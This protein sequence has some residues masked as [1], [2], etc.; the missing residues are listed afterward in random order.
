M[1]RII[2]KTF[3]PHKKNNPRPLFWHPVS[4]SFLSLA[5][6][7]ICSFLTFGQKENLT[8][9]SLLGDVRSGAI[10]SFTNKER[11][12]I[13]VQV[14]TESKTL[15]NAAI[16][17]A[18]DMARNGYF[19]HYS[20]EGLSPWFWFDRAGYEYQKAGENLAV[21]FDDSKEVVSAW[22]NSP[23]HKENILKNG[24]SEIGVGT[25]EGMYKG[26][27][28]TFVVQL[29]ATPKQASNTLAFSLE[30]KSQKNIMT[31]GEV[32][33][34]EITRI[35][36]ETLMGFLKSS[37]VLSFIVLT[38]LSL[39]IFFAI[40]ILFIKKKHTQKL[41]FSIIILSLALFVSLYTQYIF[42]RDLNIIF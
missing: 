38:L 25:A 34:I 26:K 10:I 14:L 31:Q 28:A 16:L 17:K 41:Y 6:L 18:Q 35:S 8:E 29:F 2:R 4:V 1:K 33:G 13:G 22:M 21:N 7:F 11:S 12:A 9:N 19:A 39:I 40:L 15:E 5:L 3:L 42:I 24:Y 23:T 20:P 37:A 36:T 27:K 30:K 32:Q